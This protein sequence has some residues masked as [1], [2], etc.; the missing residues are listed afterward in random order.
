MDI[1]IIIPF[2]DESESLPEL[3]EWIQRVVSQNHLSYEILMIDD[4]STDNSWQVVEELRKKN[5]CIKGH[6]ISAQLWQVSGIK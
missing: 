3:T 5:P 6:K 1:S 4:G 2:L